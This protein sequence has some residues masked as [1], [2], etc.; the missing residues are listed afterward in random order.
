MSHSSAGSDFPAMERFK[1]AH[2][3]EEKQG[4]LVDGLVAKVEEFKHKVDR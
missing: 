4:F 3:A 2:D 1:R